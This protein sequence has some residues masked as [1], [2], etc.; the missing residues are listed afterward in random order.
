VSSSEQSELNGGDSRPGGATA[1]GLAHLRD[2]EGHEAAEGVAQ[3]E[4]GVPAGGGSLHDLG[5]FVG[6]GGG[7]VLCPCRQSAGTSPGEAR[8]Q[9]PTIWRSQ[10][11]ACAASTYLDQVEKLGIDGE[12]GRGTGR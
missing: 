11:P 12:T 4:D 2:S 3:Q 9:S 7:G 1:L 5:P 8:R 6:S 10:P